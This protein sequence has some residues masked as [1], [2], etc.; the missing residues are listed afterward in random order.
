MILF[1]LP[2]ALLGCPWIPAEGDSAQACDDRVFQDDDGDGF[3]NPDARGADGTCPDEQWVTNA[4]D[5]DDLDADVTQ[6]IWYFDGDEDNYGDEQTFITE[7]ANPGGYVADATDCD[8][9]NEDV[10]PGADEICDDDDVDED[11]DELVD[12]ADL[13]V[14]DSTFSTFYADSDADSFGD[15]N[16]LVEACDLPEGASTNADDCDDTSAAAFPGGIEVCDGL[17]NDCDGATD[18][19][20]TDESTFYA[21]VDG[22]TFGDVSSTTTGCTAPDGTVPDDTD[23]DDTDPTAPGTES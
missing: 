7:C 10:N 23:C 21:D 11:C 13:G 3:G 2:F 19:N 1:V 17:D 5:C 15:A 14:E 8:D 9:T 12:D 6:N 16:A 4:A 18:V 20:A 22:D